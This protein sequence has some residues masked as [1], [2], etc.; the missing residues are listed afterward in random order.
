MKNKNPVYQNKYVFFTTN[1]EKEVQY[2]RRQMEITF[3][4]MRRWYC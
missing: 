2:W 1:C 4:Q 3:R